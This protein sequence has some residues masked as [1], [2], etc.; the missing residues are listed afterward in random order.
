MKR[1]TL[2]I[3]LIITCFVISACGNTQNEDAHFSE[4]NI[5]V[6]NYEEDSQ[7]NWPIPAEES[8]VIENR[9]LA[10]VKVGEHHALID[11]TGEIITPLIYKHIYPFSEIG[12]ARVETDEGDEGYINLNGEMVISIGHGVTTDFGG[13]GLAVVERNYRFEIINSDGECLATKEHRELSNTLSGVQFAKNGLSAF[14]A[15]YI[16]E[17]MGYMDEKGETVIAPQF[18]LAMEFND[19]GLALVQVSRKDKL[20]YIDKS[21]KYVIT[22][23]FDDASYLFAHGMAWVKINGKYGYINESGEIVIEPQFE[24]A[25]NFSEYGLGKVMIDSKYGYINAQGE[26]VIPAQYEV[27]ADFS[28]NGLAPVLIDGLF[29]FINETGEMVIEPQFTKAFSFSDNGLAYVEV[30]GESGFINE[31]GEFVIPLQTT[32]TASG[33]WCGGYFKEVKGR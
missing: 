10:L 5:E 25:Y 8:S 16:G 1:I 17:K 15:D 2:V 18:L 30:N 9:W 6:D 29:G 11:E 28:A 4:T 27:A 32:W 23:Q 33:Y 19:N 21:G 3:A 14:Y 20:G 13:N 22:P 26:V 24:N 7:T 12:L 31:A